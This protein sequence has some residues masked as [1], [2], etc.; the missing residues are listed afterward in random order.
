MKYNPCIKYI[1][2]MPYNQYR[3]YQKLNI[4]MKN[5]SGSQEL[6]EDKVIYIIFESDKICYY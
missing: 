3:I 5:I 1:I 4:H 2:Y 6:N